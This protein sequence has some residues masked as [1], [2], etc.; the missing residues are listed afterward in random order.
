[1]VITCAL[2]E[3]GGLSWLMCI[4]QR[5]CVAC[6]WKCVAAEE[7]EVPAPALRVCSRA[8]SAATAK[9]KD[10][11]GT[12]T[13]GRESCVDASLG[14]LNA[15]TRSPGKSSVHA[16]FLNTAQHSMAD[17]GHHLR[18]ERRSSF[19]V[20]PSVFCVC[21]YRAENL[22]VMIDLA[23]QAG[24][25]G[26]GPVATSHMILP[27]AFT[28]ECCH[29]SLQHHIGAAIHAHQKSLQIAGYAPMQQSCMQ[30]S[31]VQGPCDGSHLHPHRGFVH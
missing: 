24:E 30:S 29:V 11:C 17:G 1:M 27:G 13:P 5:K 18:L 28:A 12:Q 14:T 31:G 3:K 25:G 16:S 26:G 23:A 20:E 4:E 7:E 9:T 15:C 2:Q 22:W 21:L 8:V 10:T 6:G 19:Q